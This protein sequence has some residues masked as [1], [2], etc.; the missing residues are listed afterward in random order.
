LGQD[1]TS[2]IKAFDTQTNIIYKGKS[3]VTNGEF[4]FSFVVPKDIDYAFGKGKISYYSNSEF[5]DTYGYDTTIVVGGVNPN[6]LDDAIGPEISLYMND[7]KFVNGGITD[8]NPLFMASISDENGINT[9][10]NGIGHDITVIIDGDVANPIVL[11]NFYEADL[12]TYQSGKVSYDLSNLS[13]GPHKIVFKV[14]DVNNNS[15]EAT[16]DFVVVNEEEI[17]ISH[18]LN[19]PNPFTTN[20]DFYFEH[21]QVCNAIQAKV[22][23][24]TVSGKL[25]KTIYQT[26]NTMGFRSEGIN[27]NGRDE[28]GDKLARGVY[29]YRLSIET[30]QGKKAEKIEKLVIL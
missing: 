8:S 16:L 21:N 3:T 22:E 29:I 14:W 10:G 13:V 7:D 20:T 24:F 11:N 2:P 23:I 5:F 18:L 1:V 15:S 19:Y 25:V 27:W 28:F 9:T 6:G 17:G 4:T 26:V 30:E 12:D